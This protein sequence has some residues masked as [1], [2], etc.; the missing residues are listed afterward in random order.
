MDSG[1]E[2]RHRQDIKSKDN[3]SFPFSHDTGERKEIKGEERKRTG[4]SSTR[5]VNLDFGPVIVIETS[6][7]LPSRPLPERVSCKREAN[8][9]E[10]EAGELVNKLTAIL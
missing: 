3:I 7:S 8:W 9:V 10:S 1:K 2:E 6:F 4:H 5:T